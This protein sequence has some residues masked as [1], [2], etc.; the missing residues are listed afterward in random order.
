MNQPLITPELLQKYLNEQCT[1]SERAMVEDWYASLK[2]TPRYL[3]T[4][5]EKDSIS[6]QAETFRHIQQKLAIDQPGT[7][8][9]VVALP[10][11]YWRWTL[12]AV[13]SLV[14][15]AGVWLEYGKLDSSAVSE[16]Y[17]QAHQPALPA[18][19]LVRFAN[20]EPRLVLHALPDGST[21]WLR[22]DAAIT[23]PAA[24]EANR[25]LVSFEG[26]GFFDVK[27]DKNRPFIIQSGEMQVEVLGTRFNVK[28]PPR[29]MIYEVSVVS[30]SVAV[31]APNRE[32][33]TQKVVLAPKQQAI[34][35]IQNKRLTSNTI[36]AEAKKEIYEPVTILFEGTPLEHVTEQLSRRFDVRVHL[37]NPAMKTCRLTAD[38]EQ[39]PLPAILE[40]LCA[41]LD[42]TY[43][44]AGKTILIEGEACE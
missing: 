16:D 24:F 33:A 25:R 17:T 21:V 43:T 35:E 31:S 32:A 5:S 30:G 15:L 22:A 11:R 3:D 10:G 18:T 44:M 8:P 9:R 41:T 39:Q 29:E 28:A 26:E 27:S 40:M 23:Y 12:G 19:D 2:G 37:V 34:F 4:L 1:D 20:E 36:P 13:A 14:L 6:L 7:P 42:A 38:F